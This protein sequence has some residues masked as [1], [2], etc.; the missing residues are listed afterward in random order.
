MNWKKILLSMCEN[1]DYALDDNA[2]TLIHEYL[3]ECVAKKDG[4][5]ANGRLARNLYDDLVMN[6]ARRVVN[7]VS[8]AK[9]DLYTIMRDDFRP[10]R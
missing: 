10:I 5:F 1:N 3:E 7:I 6:H 2:C 4:N 9:E 8:P